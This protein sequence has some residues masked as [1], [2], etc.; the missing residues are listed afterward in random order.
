[1]PRFVITLLAGASLLVPAL[2]F[3]ASD[4]ESLCEGTRSGEQCG[5]GNGRKTPGGGDK[6]SHK[7]WPAISG[8]LWR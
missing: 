2:A 3:A 1:M 8:I 6:V 4:A 7:G 5:P